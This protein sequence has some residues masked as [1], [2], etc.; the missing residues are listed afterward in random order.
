MSQKRL[1]NAIAVF[2]FFKAYYSYSYR[3]F[4]MKKDD[5]IKVDQTTRDI[6]EKVLIGAVPGDEII[7]LIYNQP[8]PKLYD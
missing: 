5:R 3:R 2:C 8:D 7:T 6:D 4:I 1:S